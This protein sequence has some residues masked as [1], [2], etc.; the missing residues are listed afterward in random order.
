MLKGLQKQ[1][2]CYMQ[3]WNQNAK[4]NLIYLKRN[5]KIDTYFSARQTKH[6]SLDRKHEKFEIQRQKFSFSVLPIHDE[7][8]KKLT[9]DQ[10]RK[11]TIET[12][13]VVL[14]TY[15]DCVMRLA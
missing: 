12:L 15:S 9:S 2:D 7:D 5:T 8:Q 11:E 1:W 4:R 13:R 10:I 14:L 3:K 6:K